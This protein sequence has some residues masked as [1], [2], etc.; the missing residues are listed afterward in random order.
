LIQPLETLAITL[1]TKHRIGITL[2]C[3]KFSQLIKPLFDLNHVTPLPSP[4]KIRIRSLIFQIR[5]DQ[6]ITPHKRHKILTV[7]G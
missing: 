7:S 6:F 2:F 4:L 3:T 1:N 5:T